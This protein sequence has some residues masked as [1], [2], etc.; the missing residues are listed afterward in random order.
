[1]C[2]FVYVYIY[3]MLIYLYTHSR[4]YYLH[5]QYSAI[6]YFMIIGYTGRY[7]YNIVYR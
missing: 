2:M 6:I 1:M 7:R 3:I 5:M 4:Q